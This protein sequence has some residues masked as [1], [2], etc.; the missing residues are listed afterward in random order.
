MSQQNAVAVGKAIYFLTND[1]ANGVVAIPIGADGTLSQGTVTG[2][3]GCGSVALNSNNQPATPDALVS[4][5]ALTLVGDHIFAVNAGSNTLSMLAI[6]TSDAT[7]LVLVGQPVAIPGE[8]PNTVAAS[9][10]NNLVCVGTTGAQAGISCSSFSENGLGPMDKLRPFELNQTTPPVGPTNTVSQTFFSADESLL[11]TTVKGDPPTNKT[12]FLSAFAVEQVQAADGATVMTLAGVDTRSTP[13][14]T[15]VLFG[16]QVIPGTSNIFVTD[17]AFGAAILSVDPVTCEATTIAKVEVDG[18]V[19]T[20][21]VAISPATGT[22]FVTDTGLNRLVEMNIQDASIL[23]ELDLSANGDPGL[24]DLRAAGNFVYALSP[25]NGTT[26]AA[27][28]V[29]DVSGGSGSATMIQHFGLNCLAGQNAQGM[30][31]LA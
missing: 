18:Q 25:G 6:S 14:G 19:A 13:E 22:A 12:G 8:F 3:G 17:A 28:T 26:E 24:I 31:V 4:Q 9:V 10:K 1:Q 20:C 11:F 7:Q 15:A 30:A 16:S 2:T 29:I 21:W 27:V 5:S 23:S